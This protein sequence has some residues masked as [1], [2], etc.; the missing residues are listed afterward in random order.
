MAGGKGCPFCG[1]KRAVIDTIKTAAG[2]PV[3]YRNACTA[4]GGATRWFP[5]EAEAAKAW[6]TRAAPEPETSGAAAAPP[7]KKRAPRS[8]DFFIN[9]DLFLYG[10]DVYARN[11]H[12]QVCCRDHGGE[13]Y[14]RIKKADYLRVYAELTKK[15]EKKSPRG[16]GKDKK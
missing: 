3:C 2:K 10:G 15:A 6:D 13:G 9:K 16:K 14:K 4:C 12:T 1:K 5:T 8:G 7:A 11:P